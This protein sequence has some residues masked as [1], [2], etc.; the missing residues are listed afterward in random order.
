[1][2]ALA[3]Y[4][5]PTNDVSLTQLGD[6]FTKSGFF[7]DIKTASQAVTKIMAGQ[8]CGF[9][10]FT[11]MSN[12]HIIQGRLE[13]GA[14]L[15][16]NAVK[17]SPRYDYEV[18]K[19]T[20][21]V[22]EIAFFELSKRTGKWRQVGVSSFSQADAQR[23]GLTGEKKLYGKYPKNMLFARAMT[24]GV[25][26]YC[27]DVFQ[28]RAYAEGEI[29][30]EFEEVAEP[31]QPEPAHVEPPRPPQPEPVEMM[32]AKQ[33][34]LIRKL[35]KSHVWTDEEKAKAESW[36]D[37]QPTKDA[38]SKFIERLMAKI[39]ARKADE[40]DAGN[41][42][43]MNYVISLVKAD[44]D[45]MYAELTLGI[46]QEDIQVVVDDLSKMD[47]WRLLESAQE[48]LA[49]R[50]KPGIDQERLAAFWQEGEAAPNAAFDEVVRYLKN[51]FRN[52]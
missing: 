20:D 3:T 42:D 27:P 18:V 22:C 49:N 9:D 51:E 6:I 37:G 14:H 2:E 12:I 24:N 15:H 25:E 40:A 32:T 21:E 45:A 26:F 31:Q 33:E 48:R 17:R 8:A 10:P 38:A 43:E 47:A 13:M 11:S 34:E 28:A 30:G 23:A 7:P 50:G 52:W 44:G 39:P 1:M 16:A 36:L 41:T 4:S 19:H 29:S 46:D 5:Q 35:L